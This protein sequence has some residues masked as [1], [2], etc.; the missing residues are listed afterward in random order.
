[1]TLYGCIKHNK[2]LALS[3]QDRRSPSRI[4]N[5]VVEMLSK[6]AVNSK[7]DGLMIRIA[8]RKGRWDLELVFF[9]QELWKGIVQEFRCWGIFRSM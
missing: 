5:V 3:I 4:G 7:L 9:R 1:M 2:P 6:K 8:G